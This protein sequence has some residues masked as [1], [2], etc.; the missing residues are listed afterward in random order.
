M[1]GCRY[2]GTF[3]PFDHI[4]SHYIINK[5]SGAS[6][7]GKKRRGRKDVC[8][9]FYIDE[10]AKEKAEKAFPTLKELR[11]SFRTG[12]I[13][14]GMTAVSLTGA[15]GSDPKAV[16]LLWGFPGFEKNRQ[17]IIN[18]RTES[19]RE[20]PSFADAFRRARC[21]FPAGGFY[22]WARDDHRKVIFRRPEE[23][24]LYLAGIFRPFGKEERFV[25]LTRPA[26]EV[27]L[28]VHDRM[29]LILSEKEVRPWLFDT[30][31]AEKLLVSEK[32]PPLTAKRDYEQISLFDMIEENG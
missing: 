26:D 21:V 8:G 16:P 10:E 6:G 20:K 9:R 27:M 30:D 18:A 5:E 22:E 14:P 2:V 4:L 28:P 11:E 32:T 12:D 23:P 13:T 31:S 29:P 3:L 25:I 19:V 24:V 17:M 7:H 15:G 1:R